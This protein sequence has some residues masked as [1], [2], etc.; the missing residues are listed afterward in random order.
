MDDANFYNASW[1]EYESHRT[2][3][4]SH[5]WGNRVVFTSLQDLNPKFEEIADNLNQQEALAYLPEIYIES[6]ALVDGFLQQ[7][8]VLVS[9]FRNPEAGIVEISFGG[10]TNL[11][12]ALQKPLSRGTVFINSTNPDPSIAPLIDFNVN[13][14]PIDMFI[15]QS[16]LRKARKFMSADSLA[17][18]QPVE[19]TPGPQIE[20]DEAIETIM[21]ESLLNP[22]FDHP[23]GTAAMMP[24]KL[25]GVVDSCLRVYGVEGL[26]VADASMMPI[27]P[28]AHTQA[29]V[30]AV[31]EYASDLIQNC[32]RIP[33][34][35]R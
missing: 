11:P 22:S 32:Q 25:G 5:A 10:A 35:H 9:Q 4:F 6:Q 19:I 17:V 3:P 34:E 12:V 18:L 15:I 26:W 33:H 28:A 20:S 8:E 16:A 27:L 2:G 29:T 21:R 14:N 1:K 23:V 30:Y 31:A 13:S 7:R 24:R